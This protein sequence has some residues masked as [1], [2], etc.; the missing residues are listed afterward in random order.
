MSN[1]ESTSERL[2]LRSRIH[3][4]VSGE[5]LLVLAG[6]LTAE[7]FVTVGYFGLSGTDVTA[8]RYVIYPFVWINA[9]LLAVWR[10]RPA[11]AGTRRR[12]LA[13]VIALV[14]F[15]VVAYASGLIGPSVADPFGLSIRLFGSPG[16][17]PTVLFDNGL[18]HLALIPYEVIGYL[19][20][21]YLVYATVLETV[22]SAVPG[23]VGLF[24]C[25]SCTWPVLAALLTSV[26]GGSTALTSLVMSYSL[27]LSTLVFVSAVALLYW[28]PGFGD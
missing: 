26:L 10:T 16:Y 13:G 4:A 19:A 11:P 17:S 24:S 18:V 25:V 8:V 14:Y 1:P 23:I 5:T 28:R 15:G 6:L 7:L 12:R 9:G 22:G 3:S 2:R 20:L 21:A 27:D